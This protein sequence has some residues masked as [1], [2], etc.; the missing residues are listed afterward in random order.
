[1]SAS[2]EDP[3]MC[4]VCTRASCVCIP[5]DFWDDPRMRAMAAAGDLRGVLKALNRRP[6]LLSHRTLARLTGRGVSTISS[7]LRGVTAISSLPMIRETLARLGAP[8]PHPE[9]PARADGDP[10]AALE[11]DSMALVRH[12][13]S[14]PVGPDSAGMVDG[15]LRALADRYLT[16]P[17]AEVAQGLAVVS[18]QLEEWRRHPLPPGLARDLWVLSGWRSALASWMS[19]DATRPDLAVTHARAAAVAAAHSGHEG[20]AAWAAMC[21]RTIAYW[22]TRRREAAVHAGTAWEA[23]QK[24]GGGAEVITASALAQDLA[25]LGEHDRARQMLERA[26]RAAESEPTDLSD[27]GGPLRCNLARACGYWTETYLSLGDPVMAVQTAREGMEAARSEW[28]RN[29]GSERMLT[30]HLGMGLVGLGEVE[31]A[32]EVVA[33]VLEVPEELRARPLV[34]KVGQF[35]RA[36]PPGRDTGSMKERVRAFTDV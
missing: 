7:E 3:S 28:V 36:L 9:A 13:D 5:P 31:R 4:P 1:M 6:W 23:A 11:L 14:A 2:P 19:V 20:I 15:Q 21:R 12:G 29:L 24:V 8:A 10:F 17:L 32:M 18:A 25:H 22:Q 33:P 26:R 30:L 34:L 27:L 16:V 35:G